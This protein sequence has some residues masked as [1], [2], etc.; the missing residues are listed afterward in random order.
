M[1]IS[2]ILITYVENEAK[3]SRNYLC[4]AGRSTGRSDCGFILSS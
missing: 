4:K 2:K 1:N 3:L